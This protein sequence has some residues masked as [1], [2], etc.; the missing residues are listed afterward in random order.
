MNRLILS[1][2]ISIIF[3]IN[4]CAQTYGDATLAKVR[5]QDRTSRDGQGKLMLLSAAE[6]AYRADVYMSNRVFANAREHWQNL[7]EH[8]HND[9]NLPKAYMGMGRSYMWEREYA[10]AITFFDEA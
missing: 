4:L 5:E 3:S 6:H 8:Y 1:I 9:P 7:I 10:L 2:A